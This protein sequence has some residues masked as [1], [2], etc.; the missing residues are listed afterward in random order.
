MIVFGVSVILFIGLR[1]SE[2]VCFVVCWLVGLKW[3]IVFSVLLKK[4]SCIGFVLF[5]IYILRILLCMV[6]LLILCIV[7]MCL[8]LLCFSWVVMFFMWMIWLGCVE[9]VNVL[10]ILCGGIFCRIVLVVVSKIV[11]CGCLV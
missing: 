5:G 10:I 9:K 7:G 8:K 1:L 2:W 3:W 6:N 11:V 4:L